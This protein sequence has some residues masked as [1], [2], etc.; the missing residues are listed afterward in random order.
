MEDSP[1]LTQGAKDILGGLGELCYG[2]LV[3]MP[4]SQVGGAPALFSG[5][6]WILPGGVLFILL[7]LKERCAACCNGEALPTWMKSYR[8]S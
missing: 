3:D 7:R 8:S 6:F 1:Y 4:G 5:A 2:G